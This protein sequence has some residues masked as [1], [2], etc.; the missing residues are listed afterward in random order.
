MAQHPV[1]AAWRWLKDQ[2]EWLLMCF[3]FWIASW[4]PAQ[5][6]AKPEEP[7]K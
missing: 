2:S 7:K 4:R 6:D 3:L 1:S 5:D